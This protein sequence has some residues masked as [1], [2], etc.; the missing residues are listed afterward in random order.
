[1]VNVIQLTGDMLHLLSFVII[2][3][4]LMKDQSCKGVSCKTFELYLVVFCTRYLDLFMYYISFYNTSMKILFIA[5][6]IFIIY[7]MRVSPL[8]ST[9]DRVNEDKF[10]HLIIILVALVFAL[11]IN[12]EYSLWGIT[13]SFSLWLES[14][15][16]LPQIT[17]ISMSGGVFKYTAHYLASLGSYRFFYI[18]LWIYRYYAYGSLSWVSILSGTLQVALY[19]DFLYLYLTNHKSFVSSDLP[20]VSKKGSD[21]KK[22]FF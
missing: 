1:M 10:N 11:I 2:I 5:S 16:C 9:Y 7:L 21:E 4:K 13:W 22:E 3:Y 8:K 6:T 12:R 15:A 14:L 19:T 20:I 18:L 17:I